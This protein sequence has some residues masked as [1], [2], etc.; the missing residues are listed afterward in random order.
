MKNFSIKETLPIYSE[1]QLEQGQAII[2]LSNFAFDSYMQNSA[3]SP[4][5]LIN[6]LAGHFPEHFNRMDYS[7]CFDWSKTYAQAYK[8]V[9]K[10]VDYL[11]KLKKIE[12]DFE[13]YLDSEET[14]SKI[15]KV[16]KALE[17]NN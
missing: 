10:E 5:Y 9:L 4:L 16:L 14:F 8:Q 17:N 11:S 6:K 1:K 3:F 7:I 2:G 12:K 15:G 13:K